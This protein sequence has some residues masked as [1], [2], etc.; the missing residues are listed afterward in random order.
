MTLI[1]IVAVSRDLAIGK[2]GKLPW[3]YSA[4][5]K[6]FKETTTGHAVL[7]GSNT[8]RSIGRPL[9]GRVNIVLSRSRNVQVPEGVLLLDSKPAA[10]EAA[11][12]AA[13]DLYVIG[14]AQV[15][16]D[17]ADDID[18]WLVTEVPLT[19]DDADVYMPRDFLNG[20]ELESTRELGEGL[21]VKSYYRTH[22]TDIR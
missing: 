8:W 9:P 19:I 12:N 7:M 5:L 4:D 17:F 10:L 22:G 3:H 15:F 21:V 13:T 20:F 11:R 2:D 14:G 16:R 1:G 18:R 6:F